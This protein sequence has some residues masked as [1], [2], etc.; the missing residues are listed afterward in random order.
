MSYVICIHVYLYCEVKK[1]KCVRVLSI[2]NDDEVIMIYPL[3][4]LCVCTM[5][6]V[7]HTYILHTTYYI[8]CIIYHTQIFAMVFRTL[9][10]LQFLYITFFNVSNFL[11]ANGV[12]KNSSLSK[13][14]LK[15]LIEMGVN[16]AASGIAAENVNSAAKKISVPMEPANINSIVSGVK[17]QGLQDTSQLNPPRQLPT[18]QFPFSSTFQL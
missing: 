7:H 5:Y 18:R 3:N 10:D 14:P 1:L 8:Q 16:S 2:F 4:S 9:F 11:T 6:N 13:S 17:F 15:P 12:P